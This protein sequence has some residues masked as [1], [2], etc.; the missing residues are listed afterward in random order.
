MKIKALL[1]LITVL[2]VFGGCVKSST[3]EKALDDNRT[4]MLQTSN[5]QEANK[6]LLEDLASRNTEIAELRAQ[7]ERLVESDMNKSKH[8]ASI[9]NSLRDKTLD[10]E[11]LRKLIVELRASA[12]ASEETKKCPEDICDDIYG[13]LYRT[14]NEDIELG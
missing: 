9:E 12:K 10:N 8:I 11:G 7:N 14:L 6:R 4:A 2:L 5:A 13:E 3:Y 1:P